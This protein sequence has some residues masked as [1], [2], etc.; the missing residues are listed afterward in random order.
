MGPD[1]PQQCVKLALAI[2]HERGLACT[3]I[4]CEGSTEQLGEAAF[5]FLNSPTRPSVTL[6]AD[7]T[8]LSTVGFHSAS[9]RR[10][11]WTPDLT[12]RPAERRETHRT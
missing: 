7:D 8:S 12:R 9:L 10:I 3:G 1:E 4:S 5:A 2:D 11:S 6:C